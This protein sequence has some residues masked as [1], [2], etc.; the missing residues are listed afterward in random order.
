MKSYK[1]LKLQKKIPYSLPEARF[2]LNYM[3][4]RWSRAKRQLASAAAALTNFAK[5]YRVPQ[6]VR[7]TKTKEYLRTVT[8]YNFCVINDTSF[9][10]I[11][12]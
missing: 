10:W 9:A 5:S 8:G 4:F 2:R 6:L 3:N 1:R 11:T 12:I 7:A